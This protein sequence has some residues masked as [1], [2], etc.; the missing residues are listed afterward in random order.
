MKRECG[1]CQLCCRLLPVV[2]LEKVANQKCQFQKFH[3]GCSVY[4]TRKMPFEC[5]TWNC[6]WIVSTIP[7]NMARPD[8]VHYVVDLMPDAIVVKN[9]ETGQSQAMECIVVWCDPKYPLAYRNPQ[10]YEWVATQNKVLMVR[11]NSRDSIIC[12]PPAKNST[13]VWQEV[14]TVAHERDEVT[15]AIEDAIKQGYQDVNRPAPPA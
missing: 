4:R 5:H 1:E 8:R 14:V 2:S 9:N 10:L 15:A 11:M 12:F 13:G 6:R 3:K 7:D